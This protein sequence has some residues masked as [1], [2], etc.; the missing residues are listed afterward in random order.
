[1]PNTWNMQLQTILTLLHKEARQ[2]YWKGETHCGVD[3]DI[4]WKCR[5]CK[6]FQIC[7]TMRD[8]DAGLANL[9]QMDEG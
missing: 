3:F 6:H 8:L 9:E 2:A 7:K 5:H 4:N 1:M